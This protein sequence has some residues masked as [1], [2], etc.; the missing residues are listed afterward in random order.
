MVLLLFLMAET[1]QKDGLLLLLLLVVILGVF[2]SA[3]FTTKLA[4]RWDADNWSQ[5]RRFSLVGRQ[6]L[7][8][9]IG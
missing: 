4:I 9:I 2:A 1:Q 7:V 6:L 5:F 3:Y 8:D